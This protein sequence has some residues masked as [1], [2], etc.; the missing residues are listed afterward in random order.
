MKLKTLYE[1]Y[2][3]VE[4]PITFKIMSDIMVWLAAEFMKIGYDGTHPHA[5]RDTGL[6][7]LWIK[8]P[9]TSEY[10]QVDALTRNWPVVHLS[11]SNGVKVTGTGRIDLNKENAVEDLKEFVRKNIG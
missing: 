8:K 1:V 6:A 7:Q 11:S 10:V 4:R 2:G 5:E 3:D 9:H